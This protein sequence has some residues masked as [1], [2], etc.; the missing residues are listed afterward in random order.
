MNIRSSNF[1]L[2]Y[3][4][5]IFLFAL[6]LGLYS[7]LGIFNRYWSDDWCFNSDFKVLGF[8]GILKGYTYITHYSSERISL[9]L[10]SAL[11]ENFGIFG[12]QIL[13][14]L[15]ILLWCA[16]LFILLINLNTLLK[17]KL[18]RLFFAA[19]SLLIVYFSIYL[20]P[21]QFQSLYWRSA[22][23][24]YT[25]PLIGTLFILGLLIY[26]LNLGKN[27]RPVLVLIVCLTSIVGLFSEAGWFFLFSIIG[28]FSLIF[29]VAKKIE[30]NALKSNT[31]QPITI[32]LV[33]IGIIIIA[34]LLILVFCPAN[35]QRLLAY[36]ARTP[37][38]LV[39]FLSL[40]YAFDFAILSVKGLILPHLVLFTFSFGLA[41]FSGI[42][43]TIQPRKFLLFF[44]AVLL[45][46]L[47]IMTFNQFASVYVEKGPP[48]P[49][50]LI[51]SR[52]ILN[53]GITTIAAA[54]GLI[55]PKNSN[56][57][58]PMI[59]LTLLGSTYIYS[60]RTIVLES[61]TIPGFIERA[62]IW[63]ERDSIIR[64]AV[65]A[66][67]TTIQV[68]AIDGAAMDHTKDLR[69]KPGGINACAA[70]YYGIQE[71]YAPLR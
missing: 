21:N 35:A 45:A 51:I 50:A 44:I 29:Y 17:F 23:L 48:H 7:F 69:E 20:A 40:S 43:I 28:L 71:I 32:Y 30:W 33:V 19:Y 66:G 25:A 57:I 3:W 16:A 38:W 36:P 41:Y 2:I 65:T 27:S 4:F 39:P 70:Q 24:P 62:K 37:I 58:F 1:R 15:V 63:D 60:I 59:V 46:M 47:F 68:R 67:Q 55:L 12:V 6:G 42:N 9:T 53:L 10:F 34:D 8:I 22:V 26:S 18:S 14:F 54:A 11:S 49:R 64:Q 61:R 52:F 5:T 13:P 31:H 56:I